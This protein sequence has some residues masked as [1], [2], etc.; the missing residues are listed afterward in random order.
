MSRPDLLQ[1]GGMPFYRRRWKESRGDD[2]HDWGAATYYFW[3]HDGAVE[4][5]VEVYDSGVRLAYDRYHL[6][7]EFGMLAREPLEDAEWASFE[8][9]IETYQREVDGH[10]LNRK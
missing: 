10:Y 2:H 3:V 9:D 6:D 7:D 1:T 8:I 4:Q 5:Q